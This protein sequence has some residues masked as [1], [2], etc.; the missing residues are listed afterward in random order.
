MSVPPEPTRGPPVPLATDATHSTLLL[1]AV[2]AGTLFNLFHPHPGALALVGVAG[3]WFLLRERWRLPPSIKRVSLALGIITVVLLPFTP[4]PAQTLGKGVAIGGLMVSLISSVTLMARAALNSPKTDVVA[5]YLL[6]SG[7]RSRYLLMS[8]ACQLFGGLLGLAGVSM[9][10]EMSSKGQVQVDED[11]LAM[12]AAITRSLAAATL[13][14]PMFSNLTIL[15]AIYPGIQ[16]TTAL[17]LCL[18]LAACSITLGATLDWWRLRRRDLP[19][20]IPLPRGPL[21]RALIPMVLAMAAFLTFMIFAAG[22]LGVAVVACIVLLIPL[23]VLGLHTLQSQGPGRFAQ[24]RAKLRADY[25]KLPSLA[26]EATLFM[27]AG[28]GGTVIASVIPQSWTSAFGSVL[29]VSPYLACLALMAIV[30]ALAF[31]AVHPVLSVVLVGTALP[32]AMVGLPP[33]I[34]MATILVAWGLSSYATPF[35]MI[36]L[37]ANRYFGYPVT[38][39]T[40][41]LNRVFA[42]AYLALSTLILGSIALVQRGPT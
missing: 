40:V 38:T 27:A 35:S 11:R 1:V 25:L 8:L 41:H 30:I 9:L 2:M 34:H 7:I 6:S 19:E 23:V 18:A 12:V 31:L 13:W 16:W 22:V 28:C 20:R 39:V 15:L 26:G 14:S 33:I 32:P 36:A 37:M 17:P 29:A 4:D 21:L 3:L 10:M 24:A 5:R 42:P